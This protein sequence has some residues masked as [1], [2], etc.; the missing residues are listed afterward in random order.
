MPGKLMKRYF[1]FI[2]PLLIY[3][4][5]PLSVSYSYEAQV[6]GVS[7]GDTIK[8][9][10]EGKEQKIRLY[11]V[12]TPEKKQ[13]FGQKAKQFTSVM[14]FGKTVEVDP[15]TTDRYKRTV[16]IVSI[17]GKCLNEELIRSGFAWVYK[18]YCDKPMCK[19]WL[20]L[21]QAARHDKVGLWSMSS[22]V[23]PWEFRRSKKKASERANTDAPRQIS[24]EG[25]QYTV[26]TCLDLTQRAKDFDNEYIAIQDAHIL[27][28]DLYDAFRRQ[29]FVSDRTGKY[30]RIFV[31]LYSPL[32]ALLEKMDGK[33]GT[34]YGSIQCK[35]SF[36]SFIVT[37]WKIKE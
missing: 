4:I 34:L 21:E 16:G 10:N 3:A 5:F 33:T 27:K 7:D 20:K 23:P 14:V 19:E 9:L 1:R 31:E 8:V 13:D 36:G 30:E 37:G 35:P 6:V 22:P 15:V 28:T 17:K 29:V 11:G 24:F 26:W 18:Q 2:L 32:S 25:M 12:D